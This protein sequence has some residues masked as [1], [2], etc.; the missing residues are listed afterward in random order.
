MLSVVNALLVFF[1][2]LLIF[3][4]VSVIIQYNTVEVTLCVL[5]YYIIEY[6]YA[7]VEVIYVSSVFKKNLPLEE[8]AYVSVI[9]LTFIV[10]SYDDGVMFKFVSECLSIYTKHE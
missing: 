7:I 1:S 4:T 9:V 5:F 2:K 10:L 8:Y 3:I 6:H